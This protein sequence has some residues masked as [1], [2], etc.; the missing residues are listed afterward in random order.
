ML[1]PSVRAE[2]RVRYGSK[3]GLKSD[4]QEPIWLLS[5]DQARSNCAAVKRKPS[6]TADGAHEGAPRLAASRCPTAKHLLPLSPELEATCKI[7]TTPSNGKDLRLKIPRLLTPVHRP[8][9]LGAALPRGRLT[10]APGH[11]LASPRR[12][13][14]SK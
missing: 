8:P 10:P 5:Q 4:L 9:R 12:V 7:L 3:G 2:Q 6:P 1:K 14:A 11:L 13:T